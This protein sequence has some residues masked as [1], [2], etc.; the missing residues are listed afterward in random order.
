MDNLIPKKR[1]RKRNAD[2]PFEVMTE[3]EQ[4]ER[5]QRNNETVREFLAPK[6]KK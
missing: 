1:G 6:S 5:F 4:N 3:E 2:K